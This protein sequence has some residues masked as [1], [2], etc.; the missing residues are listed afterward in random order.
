MHTFVM[1]SLIHYKLSDLTETFVRTTLL[2]SIFLFTV[3]PGTESSPLTN[4]YACT[5]H[6]YCL[7]TGK[8]LWLTGL[9]SR[10][11]WGKKE[12]KKARKSF[13]I[14][15]LFE[16]RFR[17]SKGHGPHYKCGMRNQHLHYQNGCVNIEATIIRHRGVGT[18]GDGVPIGLL[19]ITPLTASPL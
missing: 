12:K 3:L 5:L 17:N 9:F 2:L 10:V 11:D 15:V 14:C 1:L 16:H 8:W 4:K 18:G 13:V 7:N 6:P 19:A